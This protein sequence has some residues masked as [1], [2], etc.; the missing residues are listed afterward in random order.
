[1]TTTAEAAPAPA[2]ATYGGLLRHGEFRALFLAQV[3]S[4]LGTM[5]AEVALTV[6]VFQRTGSPALAALTFTVGFLPYLFGGALFSGLVDRWPARRTMVAC[7]LLS[8]AVFAVMALPGIPV[9]GLLAL[10][11]AAGL[12][13]PVF[14]GTRAAL[15]PQLLGSGATYV[16]GRAVMRMVAQGSQVI[17]FALGGLLLS[18]VGA[19]SALLLDAGSFVGSSVLVRWGIRAHRPVGQVSMSLVRDSLRGVRAV[20]AHRPTRHLLLLRWLV[21]TCALAPEALAVPYV[22]ALHG[23][24]QAIGFYLAA[25]PAAMVVTDLI[26][27]RLMGP[28]VDRRYVAL[29]ALMTTAPLLGFL[30]MPGIGVAMALLVVV[31]LGYWH[32]LALDVLLLDTVPEELQSRALAVDQAGLM[33]LQGLGFGVWGAVGQL[34]SLR[35]AITIA[36]VCGVAVVL[37]WLKASR[38]PRRANLPHFHDR[39]GD[40]RCISG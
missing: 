12:I 1:M 2:R 26:A 20:L 38:E 14:G 4:M 18:F 31:G 6:L 19:R 16:L 28:R 36:G 8:A 10:A 22:H 40:A 34:L 32:G 3:V 27:G 39:V 35:V 37:A 15:L 17:G 29:G 30:A 9:A 21:P 24:Q 13:A 25:T 23:S 5:V 33:F 11:F 7:D